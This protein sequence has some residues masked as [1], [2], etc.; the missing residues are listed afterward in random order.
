MTNCALCDAPIEQN[1][2]YGTRRQ[3]CSNRCRQAAYRDRKTY[4]GT[5][6][7]EY[8]QEC[9]EC[10]APIEQTHTGRPRKYC[11]TSCRQ[12][13][14]RRAHWVAPVFVRTDDPDVYEDD[15]PA[16][17]TEAPLPAPIEQTSAHRAVHEPTPTG[18]WVV[19]IYADDGSHTLYR[20]GAAFASRDEARDA[21]RADLGRLPHS[22]K[23]VQV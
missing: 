21:V 3:Y 5:Y 7:G 23:A 15:E 8:M 18:G 19:R 6:W 14:W 4:P 13:A 10:H 17:P 1:S 22:F 11:S 20:N 12:S 16:G 2:P 9:Q